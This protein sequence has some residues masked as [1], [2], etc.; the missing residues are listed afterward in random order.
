[1]F[2]FSSLNLFYSSAVYYVQDNKKI[3]DKILYI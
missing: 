1:M 2:G 3:C